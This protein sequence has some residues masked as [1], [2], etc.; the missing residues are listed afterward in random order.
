MTTGSYNTILGNFS[1]N[2]GGLDIRTAS[3]YIVVADG[4]GNAR[5][6]WNSTGGTSLGGTAPLNSA[7][8]RGYELGTGGAA[9]HGNGSRSYLTSN[10]YWNDAQWTRVVATP[11]SQ[12]VLDHNS[13]TF[14][15]AS[16]LTGTAGSAVNFVNVV[17]VSVNNTLAL[18]GASVAAG[19]GITFP[20]T[21]SASSNANTLDD[22]E[23]GT[24]TPTFL[25]S[26]NPT[27]TFSSFLATYTKIGR[28]V[29]LSLRFTVASAS[30]GSGSTLQIGGFPFVVDSG[31]GNSYSGVIGWNQTGSWNGTQPV[32]WEAQGGAAAAYLHGY[33]ASFGTLDLSPS[34]LQAGAIFEGSITYAASA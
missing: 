22:Y 33:N 7:S 23:E 14:V 5:Q 8:I 29:T 6:V 20:A 3:Y 13:G 27:Y 32:N 1:G 16:A 11:A 25:A 19:T 31:A 15:V 18:Q 4:S 17:E 9:Y 2:Q 34:A 26:V 24:W 21:Q 12:L 10:A 30:G 28:V